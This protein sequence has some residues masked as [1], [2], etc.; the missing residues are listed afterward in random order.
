[1]QQRNS[2]QREPVKLRGFP[3]SLKIIS[4]ELKQ[5]KDHQAEREAAKK[6]EELFAMEKL[7]D[8][9]NEKLKS[10]SRRVFK[11]QRIK[12]LNLMLLK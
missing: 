6:Q 3:R 7:N 5:S 2:C 9:L 12:I 8:A 1:M 10:L 4:C 11:I